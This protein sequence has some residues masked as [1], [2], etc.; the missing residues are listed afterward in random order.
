LAGLVGIRVLTEL[1]PAH[2][3]GE[4]NLW[5]GVVALLGSIFLTPFTSTQVKY[6][7]QYR[8]NGKATAFTA[9]IMK[10]AVTVACVSGLIG[11]L[12]YGLVSW[13]NSEPANPVLWLVLLAILVGSAVRNVRIGRLNAERM[14]G[15]YA[16][17]L[18]G[19]SVLVIA[20]TALCLW[21]YPI[22]V[23]FLVGQLVGVSLALLIFGGVLYPRDAPGD[24]A[25]NAR[26][27]KAIPKKV[28]HYGLPFV[29][30]S[31]LGWLS[32][33]ADRY[34]L[35][36]LMGPASVGLYVAAFSLGSR[37]ILLA[38][39]MLADLL[40][41]VLFE[42]ENR[43]DKHKSRRVFAIWLASVVGIGLF[44]IAGYWIL[45]QWVISVLLSE[46][47][48]SGAHAILMWIGAA[49]TLY[50]LILVFENRILGAGESRRLV[51]TQA[52]GAIGNILFALL[53]VPQQGVL[54][55]AQASAVSFGIQ[56]LLT[57]WIGGRVA[58]AR[59]VR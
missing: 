18:A 47:Y 28:K 20:T 57:M 52:V 40:R 35:A 6:H 24:T 46:E 26:E 15:R 17:W 9:W 49:Y 53:L 3:F 8:E 30:L 22:Q 42:A 7:T 23:T 13:V 27:R 54:G 33:Q 50:S 12:G 43:N 45:G 32:H 2:V 59:V 25:L 16:G 55:A 56:L 21:V 31:V 36:A 1:A 48:R 10:W 39:G 58:Q 29:P 19:E 5:L 14:Q 37:P 11:I 41:P 51:I 44:G 4:A 38:N 34:V